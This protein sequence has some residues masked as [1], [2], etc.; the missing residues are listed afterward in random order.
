MPPS[1][2]PN[3]R[4]IPGYNGVYQIS[5]MGEVRS[6]KHGR[7]PGPAPTPKLL[8]PFKR[9]H[10]VPGSARNWLS[11][12]LRADG[13]ARSVP[14]HLLMRDTW[15]GGKRPDKVVCHKNGDV[16]D[17]CLNN[18]A[19]ITPKTLGER[20]GGNAG[21]IPVAK[22][23]PG[24]EITAVYPSARA[25][26]RANYMSYQA[27]LDRCNGKLKNPFALTGFSFVWDNS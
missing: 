20:T 5:I 19:F 15:M 22:I 3:W 27:V 13:K 24:G 23:L 12:N 2:D 21:R 14:V 8:R 9:H 11:V 6:W 1:S 26:A 17:N 25:A 4:D 18:L 7:W 10:K 16:T